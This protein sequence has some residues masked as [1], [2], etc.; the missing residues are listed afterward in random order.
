MT[1]TY[2]AGRRIQGL[3][4]DRTATQ[5]PAGSVG[6]WVELG[7]TTLGSSNNDITVSSL[8][9]KRYYMC[10]V[11][12][13]GAS[14]SGWRLNGDTGSNYA[15]RRSTNGGADSTLTSIDRAQFHAQGGVPE[16]AVAYWAN[17]STKEKLGIGHTVS[18]NTAGAGNTPQRNEPVFKW[19]NTSNPI[20]SFTAHNAGATAFPSGSEVVVLG[21]DPADTHT[22]NFWQELASVDLSGGASSTLD[23]GTFTAKKYLWVQAY[24]KSTSNTLNTRVQ[25]NNDTGSNYSY[26]GSGNGGSDFSGA[27]STKFIG[28]FNGGF[29]TAEFFNGFIINNASTEKLGI[30][31]NNEWLTA[32]AGTAPNRIEICG[33]WANTSNQITSIQFINSPNNYATVSR[34]K[35]WGAD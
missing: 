16:F 13:R 15:I 29:I 26:R 11:D 17:Y 25:L 34:L 24:L 20:S 1:V 22:T 9:D 6:G 7:R 21:Y 4:A 27:P 10:L 35:V 8:S 28:D 33:K 23:S 31:H 32:G 30:F 2:H 3:D 5:L 12:N 14:Q 18:Q 19:T